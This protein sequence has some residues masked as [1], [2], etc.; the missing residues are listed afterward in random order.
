MKYKS[1]AMRCKIV[2]MHYGLFEQ[3]I[4]LEWVFFPPEQSKDLATATIAVLAQ[5]KGFRFFMHSGILY[6]LE[7]V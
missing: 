3:G 1:V 4:P 2:P 6:E 7:E 5:R